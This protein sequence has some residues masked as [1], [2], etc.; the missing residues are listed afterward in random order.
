MQQP[1]VDAT[2]LDRTHRPPNAKTA[3]KYRRN[4]VTLGR[5][6]ELVCGTS[7]VTS[8]RISRSPR[9]RE[10]RA[11]TTGRPVVTPITSFQWFS[12]F[13]FFTFFFFFSVSILV[14]SVGSGQPTVCPEQD[15]F[16]SLHRE[17][18]PVSERVTDDRIACGR[19]VIL[20]LVLLPPT[21]FLWVFHPGRR[22][23]K[24]E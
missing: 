3:D 1:I 18:V 23:E 20:L 2:D 22:Y 14:R 24:N 17:I 19:P 9:F 4:E 10:L 15:Q 7:C 21:A 6:G 11:R 13:F 8:P 16:C 12:F 5:G